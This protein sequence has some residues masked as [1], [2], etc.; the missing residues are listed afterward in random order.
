MKR[1]Y[2]LVA[3]VALLVAL[4]FIVGAP[5]DHTGFEFLPMAA[6]AGLTD[7]PNQ[8]RTQ[9]YWESIVKGQPL[10]GPSGK[11]S[12]T[13][14]FPRGP[15]IYA[16]RIRANVLVTIGTGTTP[17]NETT[18]PAG[19]LLNYLRQIYYR[20]DN[21]DVF[22]DNVPARPLF[23]MN[24]FKNGTVP[25]LTD[26]AASNGT[27][28]VDIVIP[29][30]DP[31]SDRPA[32]TVLVS[33]RYKS[34]FFDIF[35]GPLTDLFGTVGTCS[36]AGSTVDV[37][38]L[39]TQEDWDE[40][41]SP[42][43]WYN[44]W[45]V[46]PPFDAS[47]RTYVDMTRDENSWLKRLYIH[48]SVNGS[49][50]LPFG[51]TNSDAIIQFHNVKSGTKNW[52]YQQEWLMAQDANKDERSL[53]TVPAGW[54]MIDFMRDNSNLSAIYTFRN[55]LQF[56]FTPQAGLAAGSVVTALEEHRRNLHDV[57]G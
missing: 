8:L 44:S 46:L 36:V 53:E 9:L 55:Q 20:G 43:L 15:G 13:A 6:L 14:E 31:D 21:G 52:P 38:I 25:R 42:V 26:V 49:T 47:Q 10:N 17:L 24:L 22:V 41:A 11:T 2:V 33:S 32:D 50:G 29:H 19:G 40:K 48:T 37:D 30:A 1:A 54:A 56:N 57:K 27:Y 39:R 45:G 5:V 7:N 16:T 35:T 12:F 51:G 23:K 3:F 28:R 4:S 18:N 34:M